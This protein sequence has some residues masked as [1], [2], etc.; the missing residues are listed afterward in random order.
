MKTMFTSN[1]L[2]ISVSPFS[3]ASS[4][5][6]IP[7]VKSP[8]VAAAKMRFALPGYVSQCLKEGGMTMDS[9]W[10]WK[11]KGK[12]SDAWRVSKKLFNFSVGS[13]FKCFGVFFGRKCWFLSVSSVID[14]GIREKSFLHILKNRVTRLH[15]PQ[16][17]PRFKRAM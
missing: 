15:N 10:Y 16:V 4:N 1:K 3:W 11:S 6:S 12:T 17:N 14:I 13:Q 5:F 8:K 2:A 7:F 9:T